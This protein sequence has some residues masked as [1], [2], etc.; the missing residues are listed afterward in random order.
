MDRFENPGMH[1]FKEARNPCRHRGTDEEEVFGYSLHTFGIGD[2][3][4]LLNHEIIAG[5]PLE[6]MTERKK[7]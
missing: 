7:R 4:A 5:H 1:L 2:G 3:G 6:H